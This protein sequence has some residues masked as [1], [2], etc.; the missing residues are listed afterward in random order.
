MKD[1]IY[2]VWNNENGEVD[3]LS[4]TK[5]QIKQK[6]KTIPDTWEIC[7]TRQEFDAEYKRRKS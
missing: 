5:N 1:L 4:G 6:L 3:Y 7:T 2:L